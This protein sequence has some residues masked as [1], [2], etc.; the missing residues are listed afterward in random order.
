MIKV[1]RQDDA[2]IHHHILATQFKT[3]GH[4]ARML[5]AKYKDGLS[6]LGK[7][8]RFRRIHREFNFVRLHAALEVLRLGNVVMNKQPE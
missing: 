6:R 7:T 2:G 4:V 8:S 1:F 3:I 5:P